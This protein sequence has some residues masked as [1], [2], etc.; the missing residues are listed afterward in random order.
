VLSNPLDKWASKL[1]GYGLEKYIGMT[2]AFNANAVLGGLGFIW[3]AL[4]PVESSTALQVDAVTAKVD[5]IFAQYDKH[6]SPGCALAVIKDGRI[7]YKR[8]YGIADL[9]HDVPIVPESVFYVGSVSKQFTAMTAALL[10]Q[11]GRLALQDDIRKYLPEIPDY[12]TPIT[13]R[14]LIYHASGLREYLRAARPSELVDNQ[15]VLEITSRQP[16]LLF[17]PGDRYSYSNTGY[18]LLAMIVERQSGVRFS[19]FAE[20]KIFAPL[21]M[22][23]SHFHDDLTRLVRNR[24]YAY[25]PK[26]GGGFLAAAP[27]PN[28]VGAGGLFTTVNDLFKWDQSLYDGRLGAPG[29]IQLIETT[30]T[31]NDGRQLETAFGLNIRQYKGLKIIEHGGDLVGY[32]AQMTRFPEQKFSVICLCNSSNINSREL[33]N[34]V[35]D[36]FLAGQFK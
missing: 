33:V 17:K 18:G 23:D 4:F 32:T 29:L 31:L 11:Q 28:R 24:A 2:E 16:D 21:G 13:V 6:D 30:G 10:I 7:I 14:H 3:L 1:E 12:G 22:N 36:L 15:R 8:G 26:P 35:T 27:V 34:R 9:E 5:Q 20:Q 19:Q 25:D